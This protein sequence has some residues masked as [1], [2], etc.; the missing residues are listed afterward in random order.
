MVKYENKEKFI[1]WVLEVTGKTID[2]IDID[3]YLEHVDYRRG[4][5]G[6]TVYEIDGFFTVS[7]L[8]EVYSYDYEFELDE[9]GDIIEERYIF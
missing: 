6:S 7:K 1:E 2:E 3:A 8:P 9:D 5:T 4:C